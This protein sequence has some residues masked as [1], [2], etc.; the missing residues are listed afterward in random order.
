MNS[1]KK[2]LLIAFAVLFLLGLGLTA[3][4]LI[5]DWPPPRLILKYGLP[6]AGGP[7]GRRLTVEGIEFLEIRPGYFRYGS[8]FWCTRGSLFGDM[9]HAAGIHLGEKS[10]HD[11]EHNE[12]PERWVEIRVGF[13]ISSTEATV[14]ELS[15]FRPALIERFN[16]LSSRPCFAACPITWEESF[17]YCNWLGRTGLGEFRLPTRPEWEYCCRAGTVS[18]YYFGSTR[19]ALESPTF[20]AWVGG[21]R[22]GAVRAHAP[23]PWGMY[24]MSGNAFEWTSDSITIKGQVLKVIAGG[25]FYEFPLKFRS[26]AHTWLPARSALTP[27]GFRICASF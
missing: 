5:C 18:E 6:P 15:R 14:R 1:K 7:T 3:T 11:T 27:C 21:K 13:W 8:E 9:C 23:N 19:E 4:W 25:A 17:D 26:S 2:K 12:C 16:V 10:E 22:L 20:Q 24:G